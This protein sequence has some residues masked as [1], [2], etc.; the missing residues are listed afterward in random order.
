MELKDLPLNSNNPLIIR[1][2]VP[3]PLRK[4]F[5]YLPPKGSSLVEL[6]PG[7]RVEVPFGRQKLVGIVIA[8]GN[9]SNFEIKALKPIGK[10]L[11]SEPSLTDEIL[12]LCLWAS[13]YY[14]HPLGDVLAH[15]IPVALRKSETPLTPNTE[16]W[17]T[18]RKGELI[19]LKQLSRAPKQLNA[20]QVLREHPKGLSQKFINNLGI[21]SPLLRELSKKG[22]A[23]RHDRP[24]IYPPWDKS[25]ISAEPG[26]SLNEEQQLAVTQIN[27]Q[28][29]FTPFL[30]NGVTGSGKTEVYL[31]AIT[32]QLNQGKQV[33]ILVPEI[34]LTPQ[35]LN[36]FKQ[37]FLAPIVLLHSNLTDNERL[38]AWRQAKAGSAAIV[39]GTRSA[40][41]TP[42]QKL[43]LI[44]IDEEH[45][46]SYKQQ[47]GFR[48]SARDLAIYRA[49]QLNIPVVLGSATPSLESLLNCRQNRYTMLRMWHRAGDAQ[50]PRVVLQDL[51]HSTLKDGLTPE[52]E[53][54]VTHTL[55]NGQ[56][57]LLFLNRRGYAPVLMCHDCGWYAQCQRC[58]ARMTYHRSPP[59]LHCHH[60]DKQTGIPKHCPDCNSSDIRSI[61]VGTERLEDNLQS[62]FP[63]ATVIRIDRDTTSRKHALATHLKHVQTGKPCILVG[64]QMLAKGHHFPKV[65]LVAIMDVDA[66][67]FASDFRAT[68]HTAQLIEQVSGR[69]G[70][71]DQ[72]GK[73]IIQTHH[74]EHPLLET[75][76]YKGYNAF[77]EMAL[78]ERKIIGL[79]PYGFLA[80]IRAEATKPELPL[81]FLQQ[82]SETFEQSRPPGI[83][84]WGPVP[85]LMQRKAGRHRFQLVIKSESRP[86]LQHQ[87]TKL[88]EL[89]ESNALSK[90]V[91]WHLDV[92]PLY[93]E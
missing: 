38:E 54:A 30:L 22:L 86:V 93:L 2:A 61:G 5:D 4:T 3:T 60:C 53:K 51:R 14:Q 58:D 46:Q 65:T 43:G 69:A 29:E 83:E 21:N 56:Q 50:P 36:R 40:L 8:T 66:G 18:T 1:V 37:R 7:M 26:L 77:A 15:A 76:L 92:D 17:M 24:I 23:E 45:D 19:D 20:L 62:H 81:S 90:R 10:I 57:A 59:H 67:L 12:K 34:G 16:H 25:K 85:T 49:K 9:T 70:R 41:F 75:L 80:L 63:K 88:V 31:Q 47:D 55:K 52:L 78:A 32:H 74:P 28:T 33:L 35:T 68:E 91:K 71:G 82:L 42:M 89:A 6:V 87:L 73:V 48:Y 27:N 72:P 44:V 79:P 39:M 64:T 13:Q 84:V 11:D